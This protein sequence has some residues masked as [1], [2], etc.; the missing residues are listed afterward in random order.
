MNRRVF[1][2]ASAAFA[3]AQTLPGGALAAPSARLLEDRWTRFGDAAGPD[4][5]AWSAFLG[6]HRRLDAAGVARIDYRAA[7]RGSQQALGDYLAALQAVDPTTLSKPAAFAF[8][9]NLYNAQTVAL[10]LE[11]YP[12]SSIKRVRGG[13]F[14]T[15]PWG[16]K[17]MR[18]GGQALSL[19]DVEHGILRPIWGDPR[20]HY[21][22]NCAAVGCPNLQARAWAPDSLEPDLD[23]A[24]RDY[25]N[26]PRGARIENGRLTVSSIY[27][28]FQTDFGGSD[29]GVIRHLA[30]YAEPA[31]A[32]ALKGVDRVAGDDYDWSLNDVA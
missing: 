11:A 22:V 27:E 32:E 29:A 6:R 12:V 18:V 26:D 21:A 17:V 23:A 13:L 15:G 19:D 10:V 24:A 7:K 4:H 9:A 1:L 31:L 16:Q 28:W 14:G 20:I 30:A 2:A 25:V 3:A 8:W 5:G